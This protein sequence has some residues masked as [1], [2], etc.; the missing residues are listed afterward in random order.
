[1]LYKHLDWFKVPTL[2]NDFLGLNSK[3]VRV[4]LAMVV[5]GH[6]IFIYSI[7]FMNAGHTTTS[8]NF[9]LIYN[10]AA[11]IQV[12]IKLICIQC[13]PLPLTEKIIFP[14]YVR[15]PAYGGAIGSG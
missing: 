6:L 7:K 15:L 14:D 3:T 9:V 11:L 5:P 8:L 1:M 13:M 10:T 4:L 2:F 12:R